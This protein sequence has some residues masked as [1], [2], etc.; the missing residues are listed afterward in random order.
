MNNINGKRV[1]NKRFY[2]QGISMRPNKISLRYN[3]FLN[4]EKLYAEV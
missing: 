3:K 2:L 4:K 1:I